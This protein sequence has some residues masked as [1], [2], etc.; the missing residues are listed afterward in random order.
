MVTK[1]RNVL[2]FVV[3]DQCEEHEQVLALDESDGMPPGGVLEWAGNGRLPRRVLFRNRS[4]ARSAI[5]RTD[6]YRQAF[7]TDHPEAKYCRVEAIEEADD[8]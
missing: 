4:D 2:G 7:G 8:E 1:K 3:M 5:K 6:H